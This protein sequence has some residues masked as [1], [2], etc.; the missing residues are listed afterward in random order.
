MPRFYKSESYLIWEFKFIIITLINMF[1]SPTMLSPL[2][3][4]LSPLLAIVKFIGVRGERGIMGIN[5][6]AKKKKTPIKKFIGVYWSHLYCKEITQPF[7]IVC[8][9]CL[10]VVVFPL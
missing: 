4:L 9:R 5:G 1:H 10:P 2:T 6:N 7:T 8:A 3:L